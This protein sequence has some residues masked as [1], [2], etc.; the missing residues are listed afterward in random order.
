MRRREEL[1]LADI[2]EACR[3]VVRFVGDVSLDDWIAN[4]AVRRS[5][6]DRPAQEPAAVSAIR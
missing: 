1:Y 6:G 3:D 2:V 5:L 4:E